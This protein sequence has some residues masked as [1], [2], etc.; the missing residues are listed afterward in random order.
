MIKV[1]IYNEYKHEREIPSIGAVYPKGIHGCIADFLGKSDDIEVRHTATFDDKEHGLTEEVLEDTDVLIF[2]SHALQDVFEDAV[3][4]RVKNYVNRGM[5]LIALHSAHYSKVMRQTLG[6]TMTLSWRDNESE[7]ITVSSPLHPIAQG[8]PRQFDL[9]H[10]EMYGE[11]FDIPTPDD[12]VFIGAFDT[13]EVFRSGCTFT[14]GE[15]RIFYFQP[16]HE[17]Y[18]AYH[19]PI[20]QRIIE[21]AVKWCA[22]EET[23]VN[24]MDYVNQHI[25][26][27]EWKMSVFWDHVA[28]GATQSGKTA[29]TIMMQAAEAGVK[30]LD[31]RLSDL[32]NPA[33]DVK[34]ILDRAQMNV[35]CIYET[36]DWG[37]NPDITLGKKHVDTAA[38]C[39][40]SAILVIPGF[41]D[42]AQADELKALTSREEIFKYMSESKAISN[43]KSALIQM[44]EYAKD[45]GVSVTLED[46]DGHFAPFARVDELLWFMQNVPGL[47][48]TLDMGNFAYSDE[49]V[50][51]GYQTLQEYIVHVHCK[52]RGAEVGYES[53]KVSKGLAAVPVGSGYIPI[54]QLQEKLITKGYKGYFAIEHFGASDQVQFILDSAEFLKNI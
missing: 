37:N 49:D 52:D 11:Y 42:D 12:V 3:A 29:E 6:T 35:S 33:N 48:Y 50:C 8:I 17:E 46:Y 51:L 25:T 19:T 30:G 4:E 26:T 34:G 15:G 23:E 40:A 14:R 47:K 18:P 27:D 53:C 9:I 54:R 20:I 45:K 39:G 7:R 24:K 2:W 1:T 22:K 21:N 28:E 43:M 38:E 41:L 10:E 16:G 36:Y 13:G 31:V 32:L 5:G 44:V